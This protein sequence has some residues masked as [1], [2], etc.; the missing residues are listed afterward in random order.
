MHDFSGDWPDQSANIP[1]NSAATLE[2]HRSRT[3]RRPRPREGLFAAIHVGTL[4]LCIARLAPR[5]R[6]VG[7]ASGRF[8]WTLTLG[9]SPG[10]VL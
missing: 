5:G 3:R 1:K 6:G 10:A 8:F 2:A 4:P 9:S 7:D